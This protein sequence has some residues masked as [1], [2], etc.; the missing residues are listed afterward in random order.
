MMVY[1]RPLALNQTRGQSPI[2]TSQVHYS[3]RTPSGPCEQVQQPPESVRI[4]ILTVAN[5]LHYHCNTNLSTS[6]DLAR[7]GSI[8]TNKL[9]F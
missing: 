7:N 8:A 9:L 5:I 6:R 4:T 2:V 1:E 3:L